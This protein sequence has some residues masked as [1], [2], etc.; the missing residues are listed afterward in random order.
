MSYKFLTIEYAPSLVVQGKEK[1]VSLST[2]YEP[3]LGTAMET[4]F[5]CEPRCQ[6]LM[7]SMAALAALAA[8]DSFLAAMMAL[9]LC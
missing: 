1:I 3:S 9:P 5:P 2:P 6:S 4:Q 7:W 8:L